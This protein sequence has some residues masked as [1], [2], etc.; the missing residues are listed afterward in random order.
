MKIREAVSADASRLASLTAELGYVADGA[1]MAAR[2]DRASAR[3]DGRIFVAIVDAEIAGW[4][5]AQVTE[6]LE[7]GFRTEIV[8]LVVGLPFRRRGVGQAL[9]QEVESWAK[10]VG[11]RVLVVRSNVQRQESHVFYPALGFSAAK[12]QHVYRKLLEAEGP[13]PAGGMSGQG[14]G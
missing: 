13:N 6:V 10:T 1:T 14:Q 5:Q 4:V 12:T 8:G 9:V 3:R 11:S 2:I 7:S